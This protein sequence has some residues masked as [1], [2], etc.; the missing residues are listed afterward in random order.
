MESE[1]KNMLEKINERI[2]QSVTFKLLS[3]GILI[4][5]LLIPQSMINSLIIERENRMRTTVQE[6]TS[7][8]SGSQTISGPFLVVPYKTYVKQEDEKEVKTIVKYATFLPDSL[9]LHSVIHPEERY[10]GIFK[11]VVYKTQ[12]SITGNFPKPDFSKW[13]IAEADILWSRAMLNVGISDLRGIEK[14][15]TLVSGG[16]TLPFLPGTSMQRLTQS[17]IH[18]PMEPLIEN[19]H[20]DIFLLIF[21]S[22]AVKNCI[23]FLLAKKP[24]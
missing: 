6:V 9:N 14:E 8:W 17:G 2:S 21:R 11:V 10:R 4:L 1:N 13:D 5:I 16:S 15:V 18:L 20:K 22:K 19:L 3:I 7:K 12:L 23:L 24:G